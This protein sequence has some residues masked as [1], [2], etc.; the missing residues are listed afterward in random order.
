[1]KRLPPFVVLL[2]LLVGSAARAAPGQEVIDPEEAGKDPDFA[3]QGEYAGEGTWPG[4]GKTRIG[5]QAIALGEGKVRVEVF[6]GG[7]P[8]DGWQR[9]DEQFAMDGQREEGTVK[10]TGKEFPAGEIAGGKL[11]VAG[12]GGRQLF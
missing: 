7:L 10:L 2:S 5:A 4:G 12:A 3:L 11:T 8:G 6:Q 1:M 9:G